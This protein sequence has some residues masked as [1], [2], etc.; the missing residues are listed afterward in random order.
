MHYFNVLFPYECGSASCYLDCV[1]APIQ[2]ETT[3]S[4]LMAVFYM[5]LGYLI[6]LDPFP[7]PVPEENL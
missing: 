6:S 3:I 1:L 2:K 5:N 7:L 4:I